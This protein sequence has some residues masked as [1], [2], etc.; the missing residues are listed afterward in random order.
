MRGA[1]TTCVTL[2]VTEGWEGYSSSRESKSCLDHRLN[3][4]G[5][6]G[7]GVAYS[8]NR[9]SGGNIVVGD[10]WLG[11]GST[12]GGGSGGGGPSVVA[13]VSPSQGS[14]WA[15]RAVAKIGGGGA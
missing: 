3:T 5:G 8:S 11:S 9:E 14:G 4:T 10:G 13:V 12:I 7:P 1:Q 6:V 15:R 2:S